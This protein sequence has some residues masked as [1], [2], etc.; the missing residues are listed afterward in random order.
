VSTNRFGIVV[1]YYV[2][3]FGPATVSAGFSI[4]GMTAIFV[5]AFWPVIA[6]GAGLAVLLLLT[7]ASARRKRHVL[8][9]DMGRSPAASSL[10]P[11]MGG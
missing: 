7:A 10:W 9:P 6:M 11:S 5:G 8:R 1:A 4:I 3:A 2:A